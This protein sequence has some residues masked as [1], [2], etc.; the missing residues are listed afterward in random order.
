MADPNIYDILMGDSAEAQAQAR[1]MADLLRGQQT[2]QFLMTPGVANKAAALGAQAKQ[3]SDLLEKA[4]IGRLHYGEEAKSREAAL[5]Q[6]LAQLGAMTKL[7]AGRESNETKLE[8]ARLRQLLHQ[9]AT[10][11]QI[12]TGPDGNFY[13][14]DKNTGS[15]SPVGAPGGEKPLPA[16]KPLE[17]DV[18]KMT[19]DAA[20]LARMPENLALLKKYVGKDRPGGGTLAGYMPSWAI[21]EEG[22]ALR[23]A[24]QDIANAM[25]YMQ[26]GKQ[27]NE[28]EMKRINEALGIGKTASQQ[29]FNVGVPKLERD[30]K[31]AAR[32]YAAKYRP[33]VHAAI[34]ARD[35]EALK[36]LEAML[37]GEAPASPVQAEGGPK[38]IRVDA[39]GNVIQ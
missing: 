9:A 7:Q 30:L 20:F 23:Q 15:S 22:N 32:T 34:K 12:V 33:E 21:G 13:I 24:A 5:K 19:Q 31:R 11:K 39:E 36:W 1:A 16:G 28:A 18:Q 3:G 14:V 2:A 29:A 4:A 38:R 17:P 8:V 10:G 37:D 25:V 6:S 35:P 26:S 27:I